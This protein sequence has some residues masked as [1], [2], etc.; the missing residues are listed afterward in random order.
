[1]VET[2]APNSINTCLSRQDRQFKMQADSTNLKSHGK[3][4]RQV[5]PLVH[6]L[7]A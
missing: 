7:A 5:L 4:V 6:I 3:L 2:I 1:M